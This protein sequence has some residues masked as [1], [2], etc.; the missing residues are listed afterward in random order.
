MNAPTRIGRYEIIRRLGKSMTEVYLAMDTV[1]NRK[2][3]L[4]LIPHGDDRAYEDDG[5]GGAARGG[6][7]EGTARPRPARGGDLRVRRSRRLLLR[8][9]AIRRGA[10]G[11]GHP[12]GGARDRTV[13]RG[14]DRAGDLRATGQVSLLGT[15]GGARRHQA[16]EHP[17]GPERHSAAAGFRH[18]QDA[19]R[20]L[21]CDRAPVRQSELLLAGAADARTRWIRSPICGRWARRSTKCWPACRRTRRKIRA[22]WKG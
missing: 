15:A 5:G 19:A 16:I 11:G 14:G 12:G 22:S 3:A 21:Q 4:K 8:R 17:P 20:G 9:H 7:P 10:H 6:D 1:E 18:R 13:P 2:V